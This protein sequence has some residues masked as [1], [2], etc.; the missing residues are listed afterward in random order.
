MLFVTTLLVSNIVS[1]KIVSAGPMKFD[2]GTILFPLAYIVGD[3]I[4]EVYGY[5][6]MRQLIYGGV[7]MLALMTITFFVVQVL[8]ADASWTG[9]SAFDA[10]LGVVWRLAIGSV[11]ALFIGEIM[12]AYVMGSMKMSTKGRG[13]W[14]RMI[15][16]SAVGSALDTIIFSTIAFLGT[17]PLLSL[18]QLIATV[19]AIKM[20][21]EICVSPITLKLIGII[22]QKEAL[23]TFEQPAKYL[24]N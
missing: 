10:T 13:L 23:D 3:I 4:T 15:G 12:N 18:L 1:V 24:V 22:K 7:S 14:N 21:V 8:P 20:A 11:V 2:A 5:R 16:S 9:Q 19:F 6:K 17:M